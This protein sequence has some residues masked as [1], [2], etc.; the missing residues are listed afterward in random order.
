[1]SRFKKRGGSKGQGK[2]AVSLQET[3]EEDFSAFGAAAPLQKRKIKQA[4]GV[5]D[6]GL[7]GEAESKETEA[8]RKSKDDLRRFYEGQQDYSKKS[9]LQEVAIEGT[10]GVEGEGEGESDE[11]ASSGGDDTTRTH[12]EANAP[13]AAAAEEV[14]VLSLDDMI[15]EVKRARDALSH[16]CTDLENN[17]MRLESEK[18]RLLE[19]A[20]QLRVEEEGNDGN[21]SL[22]RTKA[23]TDFRAYCAELVGMLREK[24]GTIK[25]TR[26]VVMA[27]LTAGTD[28]EAR[29]FAVSVMKDVREDLS[30]CETI[31]KAFRAFRSA[32]KPM[33]QT[34]EE[35]V[36]ARFDDKRAMDNS[37]DDLYKTAFVSL[38]LPELLHPLIT[39]DLLSTP[40]LLA[41]GSVQAASLGQRTWFT[42]LCQYAQ[43][44]QEGPEANPEG[45]GTIVLRVLLRSVMPFLKDSLAAIAAMEP[46]RRSMAVPQ[47]GRILTS[48]VAEL[49]QQLETAR[50]SP[51][52]ATVRYKEAMSSLLDTVE[53]HEGLDI[54]VA[55]LR[56]VFFA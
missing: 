36:S 1:M 35:K 39:I 50:P 18:E 32:A 13:P 56:Q 24:G 9:S 53:A 14:H 10:M 54:A 33:E 31:L 48:I 49:G 8:Q 44:V 11:A 42:S 5:L 2:A 20:P 23:L 25:E 3:E 7:V 22:A 28:A 17:K 41:C 26:A 45:D 21:G 6:L 46:S 52:E 38:S 43:E 47:V 29:D 4:P 34:R 15:S 12:T 16:S 40:M 27:S 51:C 30:Q 37:A 19:S 55:P